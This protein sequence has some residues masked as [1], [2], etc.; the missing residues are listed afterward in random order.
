MHDLGIKAD[1]HPSAL[2]TMKTALFTNFSN[3]EFIGFWDGKGKKFEPGQSLYMPDY[4]AEHFAKHLV[5]R[6]LLRRKPDGSLITKNGDK[7]VS[8]KRPKDV[9]VYMELFNKA[10]TSD[11]LE[12]LGEK[13]D[14][15]D[16]LINVANKNKG[17]NKKAEDVVNTET[18]TKTEEVVSEEKQDP[19]K[20]QIILPPDNDEDDDDEESFK[21]KP[22]DTTE[23]TNP[24]APLTT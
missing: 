4:L 23:Q 8:P 12:E 13:K 18:P 24:V 15:I 11:E 2:N 6:E 1:D 7:Y 20:P 16:T 21:G 9:P 17:E 14:D 22:V 19:T 5:N 3:E 10:Y